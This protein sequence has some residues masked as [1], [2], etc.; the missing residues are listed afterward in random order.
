MKKSSIQFAILMISIFYCKKPVCAQSVTVNPRSSLVMNGPVFLV[1]KNAALINNNLVSDDLGTVQFSG[2][3][4]SSISYLSGTQPTTLYNLTINKNTAGTALKSA[5][6]VRNVLGVYNG[7]LFTD[8][9]LTLRSDNSLT[10]RVDV[11]PATAAI[12]GKTIVE[13]YFPARRA[14]R[15]VTAPLSNTPSIFNTWQNKGVYIT[16]I[17]TCVSGSNPTGAGGNGLDSSPQNNS[18]MKTWDYSSQALLP[19]LNTYVALS[20]GTNGNADNTGYFLF[21]RGDRNFNNFYIPNTNNTTLSSNGE[22]QVGTQNFMAVNTS[23]GLTLIGNPFASPVDFNAVNRNNLVKRFYVWDPSLNVV[24]GY[25]MLDDLDNDGVYTKSVNTSQQNKHIQSGQAFFVQTLS[26]AVAGISFPETC[27]SAGNNNSLFRP[28]TGQSSTQTIRFVLNMPAS[29][30]SIILADE[31]LLE[32]N[33]LFN[34]TVNLDDAVKFTNINENIGLVRSTKLL[35]AERRSLLKANDTIFLKLT[36]TTQRPYQLQIIPSSINDQNLL[37]WL[38]DSYLNSS[39]QISLTNT[40]VVDFNIDGNT[41]SAAPDRFKIVFKQVQV[42]PVTII[43]IKAYQQNEMNAIEW[44]VTNEINIVQYEVE[45]SVNGNDFTTIGIIVTNSFIENQYRFSD[46][47]PASGN[48]FYRIKYMEVN[49]EWKYTAIVRVAIKEEG[50]T[51][52]PNPVKDNIIHLQLNNYPLGKYR[53]KLM[54]QA[55]QIVYEGKIQN[56]SLSSHH[57]IIPKKLLTT[58]IYDLQVT[59]E[60][61]IITTKK[62]I[63]PR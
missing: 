8:S 45:R 1:I 56:T 63:V 57:S 35:T 2:Y 47:Q 46:H 9:N 54:N 30:S 39:K 16:S 60:D 13:R 24:G 29:D 37:A 53:V 58:G 44:K 55:G 20:P 3:K 6:A 59:G 14:W 49:G 25:V 52:F 15:L 62:I 27:K 34:D 38:E 50:M 7:I 32:C 19:V 42:L 36:R 61:N 41:A 10:A 48:N 33:T 12:T 4:D 51:V 40:S 31:A 26:N 22:L 18:S 23:G 5:V 21:V 11:V 43:S 28:R 17:N